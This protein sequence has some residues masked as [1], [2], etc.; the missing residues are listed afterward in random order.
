M[1]VGK[2]VFFFLIGMFVLLYIV[3]NCCKFDKYLL[4][5]FGLIKKKLFIIWDIF[6]VLNFVYIVY[7]RFL[8]RDLNIW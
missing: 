2:W 6:V 8:L 7:C 5:F 3:R 4:E 1:W